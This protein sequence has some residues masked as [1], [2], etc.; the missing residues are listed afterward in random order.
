MV[1]VVKCPDC[2]TK[3]MIDGT[4]EDHVNIRIR[5]SKKAGGCGERFYTKQNIVTEEGQN[6]TKKVISKNAH[7]NGWYMSKLRGTYLFLFNK[8]PPHLKG[9]TRK[10]VA[11]MIMKGIQDKI[12]SGELDEK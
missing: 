10:D 9:I 6:G 4:I 5:C 2:G 12:N 3:R 8:D 7:S 11:I 1:V